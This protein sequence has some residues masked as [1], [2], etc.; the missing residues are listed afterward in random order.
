[1]TY[2]AGLSATVILTGL[3]SAA[4]TLRSAAVTKRELELLGV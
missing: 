2:G 3:L 1:V 4:V